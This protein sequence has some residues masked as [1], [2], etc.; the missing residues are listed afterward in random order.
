MALH[1]EDG[2]CIATTGFQILLHQ[3]L[4]MVIRKDADELEKLM[5]FAGDKEVL[6]KLLDIKADKKKEFKKYLLAKEA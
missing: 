6:D 4:V 2:F 1:L 3:R 5:Q